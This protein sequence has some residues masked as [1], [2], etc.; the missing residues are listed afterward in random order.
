MSNNGDAEHNLEEVVVVTPHRGPGVV[1]KEAL[2]AGDGGDDVLSEASAATIPNYLAKRAKP[3]KP[4][5]LV[6]NEVENWKLF[7]KRWGNYTLLS[8]LEQRPNNYQVAELE[9]CLA[10]DALKLL[11]SF[12][13][14]TTEDK[15]TVTEILAKFESY[16]MGEVNETYERFVFGSRKQLDDEPV[17]KFVSDLRLLVKTCHY[18]P[19]CEPSLLRDRI[20]LGIRDEATREELLKVRQLDLAKCVDICRANESA[21]SHRKALKPDTVHKI[22]ESRRSDASTRECL[23]CGTNHPM[24][25]ELCP[26]WGKK[27]NKCDRFNHYESKC[28][29]VSHYRKGKQRRS[30]QKN[31]PKPRVNQ[32][33]EDSGTSESDSDYEW[34]NQV[35]SVDSQSAK[36]PK[37]SKAV[38][39]RMVVSGTPVHFL[40]DTGASVNMLPDKYAPNK[41]EPYQKT[42]KMWNQME[43]VPLGTCRLKVVNPKNDKKYSIPFVVFKGEHQPILGYQTSL[44]LGL[45][46][47][48][49]HNFD[50]VASITMDDYGSVFD[51]KLGRLPGTQHLQLKPDAKPTIMPDRRV[52]LAVRPKLQK[53]LARLTELGV[54]IPVEEPTPWVSQVVIAHKKAGD[55]RV[56]LDPHDVNKVLMREHYTLPVLDDVL[57]EL[58]ESRIF[59]KA[60]LSSGYW[61]VVL[62]QESSFLTT[63]QTCFG[64]YRFL[65]LPF[66]INGASEYFQKK[67]HEALRGLPGIQCIADDVIIHGKTSQEHNERMKAFLHRCQE[68]G[69]KLNREKLELEA[70]SIS[71]MGHR[72]SAEGLSVDPTKIS[73]ITE[74]APPTDVTSLRKFLGMINYLSK[75]L[76]NVTA[77]LHP[78]HNLLKSDVPWSWTS[79]QQSAFELVKN[80]LTEAPVLA[81]YDP[82]LPL[83]L[84]ND[85]SDYG[86]GTALTQKGRPIAFASRSLSETERRYAQIEKEM[87]AVTY[88]LEKFHHFTFGRQVTVITDHKPLVAICSKPL[89]KAPKRLQNLLLRAQR[90]SFD[91]TWK[92]GKDIPM[93]DALSRAPTGQPSQDEVVNNVFTDRIKQNRLDQ[94]RGA[95][96]NDPILT[97]LGSLI[98]SGWPDHRKDAPEALVPFF[99]CRDELTIHDGIIYRG[100]RIV[101][102]KSLQ[103]DMKDRVHTGHLGIN[104]CLRRARDLLYWPGM[105]KEIRQLVET[106][107]T[108]SAYMDRQPKEP[109]VLHD[110]PSL[111]WQKVGTD[112]FC[113]GGRDYLLTVDY[114]SNFFEIDLLTDTTSSVVINKLKQHFARYGI[115]E[116]LISDNGPQYSS[117]SFRSFTKEW[118][119]LHQTSSPGNSQ[120][121]GAAE[122]AVKVAK[123]LLKKS[124]ASGSDPFLGLLNLRN[125]P[126]EGLH[127]SPSQRLLGRRSNSL[128]PAA[129]PKLLP[130]THNA[131]AEAQR[132]EDRK[133][134]SASR[135]PSRS[136]KPLSPGDIVRIQP[137]DS[138]QREWKQGTVAGQVTPRSYSVVTD[139]GHSYRR[140]RRFLRTTKPAT[141]SPPNQ[142][143]LAKASPRQ[144]PVDGTP[145]LPAENS[146]PINSPGK[147][148]PMAK[149]AS[150]RPSPSTPS[151]PTRAFLQS[152]TTPMRTTRCGRLVRPPVRFRE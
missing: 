132:K 141:H 64:R 109:L 116:T 35:T 111:P 43:D 80:R 78:L 53:E 10:D 123:K 73:A 112:L 63:F 79:S 99:H 28:K 130:G 136:L 147:D 24:K 19:T 103:K 138:N 25:K 67:L 38:K 9:N 34:C 49:T 46:T 128:L 12:S 20:V 86:L 90:Y 143:S 135:M 18:C 77:E 145:L 50:M 85:A 115:P 58:R 72:I 104:S 125:T 134:Q 122:A 45:V 107:G 16:A 69:I 62:D 26:A 110:T 139:D 65:R 42:L 39:C 88:G 59:S 52:P 101:I 97:A 36:P 30:K 105:S 27:C 47:V 131:Q 113:W 149:N 98:L 82:Q 102:P 83:T 114:Y 119:I 92:P 41:L 94:I 142:V 2:G 57:H 31:Q 84:E 120:A 23:F 81:F 5:S 8:G 150:R 140:N 32:L 54:I 15:R 4:L 106:C 17:E 22:E 76:P 117:Q 14:D 148:S 44:Q 121:N 137:L 91:I 68:L 124:K 61:H 144:D 87:L 126:T 51:G 89:S 75:F 100:D 11:E 33:K 37:N 118:G 21:S 74:M 13:F 151:T 70:E 56:C 152:T 108:C 6:E 93:A 127:T 48:E 66:G 7:K 129:V 146:P 29:G 133:A 95:T 55:I 1:H 96:A 71:F 3:P 40:I 60:D